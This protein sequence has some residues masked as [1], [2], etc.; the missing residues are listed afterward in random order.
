MAFLKKRG[1]RNPEPGA[2]VAEEPAPDDDE[3]NRAP[4]AEEAPAEEAAAEE[5]PAEE[6]PTEE[7]GE[8]GEERDEID[9][10]GSGSVPEA[11]ES[12]WRRIQAEVEADTTQAAG[13]NNTSA[14]EAP[15]QGADTA[16]AAGA[17]APRTIERGKRGGWRPGAGRPRKLFDPNDPTPR[18][19]RR[20]PGEP[21]RPR[22]RPRKNPTTEI[23]DAGQI[24]GE[25]ATEEDEDAEEDEDNDVED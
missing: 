24:P 23:I 1:R 18:K 16:Q 21:P 22:G 5:A 19:R 2:D 8:T 3:D 17:A 20:L 13:A 14:D 10:D 6:A 12:G 25:P 9:E 15:V 7:E 4:A 11:D